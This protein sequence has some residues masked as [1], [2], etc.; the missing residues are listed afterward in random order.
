MH[1]LWRQ[2]GVHDEHVQCVHRG[3]CPCG[4]DERF[5]SWSQP[6]S[7]DHDFGRIGAVT[8]TNRGDSGWKRGRASR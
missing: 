1:G 5:D 2:S 3:R 7:P 4:M 6:T 8:W